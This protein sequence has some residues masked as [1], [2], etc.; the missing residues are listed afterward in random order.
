MKTGKTLSESSFPPAPGFW[1]NGMNGY[2]A[3]DAFGRSLLVK[4]P[5]ACR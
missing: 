3:A 5:F 2:D 4:H 1:K